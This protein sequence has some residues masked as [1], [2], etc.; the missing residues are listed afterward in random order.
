M[1]PAK[2]RYAL[3]AAADALDEDDS[4]LRALIADE[5]EDAELTA[6]QVIDSLRILA[7]VMGSPSP[8]KPAPDPSPEEQAEIDRFGIFDENEARS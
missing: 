7:A 6:E 1:N 3:L 2:T 5:A 4:R 8:R